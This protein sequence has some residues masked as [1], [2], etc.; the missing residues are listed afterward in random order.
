M[1]SK[2]ALKK[3]VKQLKPKSAN[4]VVLM[5]LSQVNPYT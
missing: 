5:D 3:E 1:D 2:Y 4:Q